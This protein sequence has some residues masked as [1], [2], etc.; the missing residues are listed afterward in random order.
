[1]I[2]AM[3]PIET[4]HPMELNASGKYFFL[5]SPY[6]RYADGLEEAYR[7]ACRAAGALLAQGTPVY[8][9]IA[10]GHA[11]ER[12]SGITLTHDEWMRHCKPFI[13]GAGGVVVLKLPGWQHSDGVTLERKIAQQRNMV[14]FSMEP[15]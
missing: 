11:I 13:Y 2:E 6:T 14:L 3:R 4:A 8:S 5:S 10:H 12:E 15:V 7:A 9:P 1:M